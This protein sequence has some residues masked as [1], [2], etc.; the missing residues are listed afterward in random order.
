MINI[1]AY[2]YHGVWENKTGHNAPLGPRPDEAN[3]EKDLNVVS[4]NAKCKCKHCLSPPLSLCP[5]VTPIAPTFAL[6]RLLFDQ[7]IFK[8]GVNL[9]LPLL[10]RSFH[11]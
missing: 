2:D 8:Y 9:I 3:S 5:F 11:P 10:L 1:M 4:F 6:A 7:S